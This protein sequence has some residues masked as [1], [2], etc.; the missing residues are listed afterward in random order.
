[1]LKLDGLLIITSCNSTASELQ[2]RCACVQ[3]SILPMREAAIGQ[4][5]HKALVQRTCLRGC[6]ACRKNFAKLMARQ[7]L[8]SLTK[9]GPILFSN[10]EASKAQKSA[11]S[12]FRE[13]H[14]VLCHSHV[15]C[16]SQV[17]QS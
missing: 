5:I 4:L 9:S 6:L 11:L 7:D 17:C 12:A 3:Y 13:L 1:M 16:P 10:L 8:H 14:D 15:H 2:V